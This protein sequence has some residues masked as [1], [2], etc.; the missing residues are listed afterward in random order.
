[1]PSV[2]FSSVAN[3]LV[4]IVL[5]ETVPPPC[6]SPARGEGMVYIARLSSLPLDGGG[7]GWGCLG[8]R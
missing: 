5:A 2:A 8:A 4:D 7:L 3:G 6:P 1:M